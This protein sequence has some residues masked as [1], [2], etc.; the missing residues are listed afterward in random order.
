MNTTLISASHQSTMTWTLTSTNTPGYS[1]YAQQARYLPTCQRVYV[2]TPISRVTVRTVNGFTICHGRT[3]SLHD[4]VEAIA[5]LFDD[6]ATRPRRTAVAEWLS[7][8]IAIVER[9]TI[10]QEKTYLSYFFFF[11]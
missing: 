4:C 1:R 9:S 8:R 7:H 6:L 3:M 10:L 5:P 2:F 11:H